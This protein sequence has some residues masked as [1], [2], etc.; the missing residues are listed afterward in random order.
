MK[1][2][3]LGRKRLGTISLSVLGVALLALVTTPAARADAIYNFTVDGCSAVCGPQTPFGTIDLH[4][5]NSTTVQIT[6][7][8]LNGNE[9]LTTGSHVGFAFNV[10]GSAVTLGTL[11]TGWKSAG[12]NLS[13]PSFGTFSNGI[14]CTQG[15]WTS[16]Q[17]CAGSDPWVGTLQF[18]VSR[19]SGLT[20][21]DFVGDNKGYFF[22]ADIIS[23][24]TGK[25]GPIG[26][27]GNVTPVP[28]PG[29][30][31]MMGSGV[32][33]LAFGWRKRLCNR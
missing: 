9:F 21:S 8:M 7:S 23:G 1:L 25:T 18:D 3:H 5:V 15:N 13:Q 28:E 30:L 10:K 16:K 19:A 12:T 33:S 29:T 17:G 2:S 6:V 24:M 32:L 11:P 4:A 27:K 31:A 26:A 14:D 22:S 20:L